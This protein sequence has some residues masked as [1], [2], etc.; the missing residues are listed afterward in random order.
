MHESIRIDNGTFEIQRVWGSRTLPE[1]VSQRLHHQPFPAPYP[2]PDPVP[3][4]D[5]RKAL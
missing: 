5:E 3:G 1:L 2:Y 4:R